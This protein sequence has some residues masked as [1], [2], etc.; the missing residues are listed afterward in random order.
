L[1]WAARPET[2]RSAWEDAR[3]RLSAV[4]YDQLKPFMTSNQQALFS[5]MFMTDFMFKIKILRFPGLPAN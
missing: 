2:D 1:N 5:R 4:V 3:G